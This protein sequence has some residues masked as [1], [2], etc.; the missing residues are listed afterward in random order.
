VGRP[1]TDGWS[2]IIDAIRGGYNG[3]AMP[4]YGHNRIQAG[5]AF[6]VSS[7][8]YAT[9]DETYGYDFVDDLPP[10][11]PPLNVRVL[12]ERPPAIPIIS[13]TLRGNWPE[14]QKED[15]YEN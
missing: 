11:R 8:Y 4:G 9:F 2:D 15:T 7:S 13:V 6:L 1:G 3:V 5:T 14:L 10:G 12:E